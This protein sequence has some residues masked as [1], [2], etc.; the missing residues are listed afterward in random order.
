M[1]HQPRPVL[2]PVTSRLKGVLP[3]RPA[4]DSLAMCRRPPS[5]T[6]ANSSLSE[7]MSALWTWGKKR[8]KKGGWQREKWADGGDLPQLLAAVNKENQSQFGKENVCKDLARIII[9]GGTALN[10]VEIT[11]IF[12]P[13]WYCLNLSLQSWCQNRPWI[14]ERQAGPLPREA[15][16]PRPRPK[17]CPEGR[18]PR[19]ESR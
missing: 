18:A 12:S 14:R 4:E 3:D 19:P 16:G 7:T 11:Q 9:K 5:D 2:C 17:S 15:G 13:I 6:Q 8:A 10:V 1:M